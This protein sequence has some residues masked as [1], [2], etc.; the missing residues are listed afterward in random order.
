[1]PDLGNTKLDHILSHVA[2]GFEKVLELCAIA[3]LPVA[4]VEQLCIY[5][6]TNPDQ[7]ISLLIVLMLILSAFAVRAVKKLRK[8]KK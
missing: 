5:G 4:I 7:V 1:M 3:F 2:H 8:E 6:V